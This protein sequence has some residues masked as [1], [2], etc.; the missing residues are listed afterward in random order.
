MGFSIAQDTNRPTRYK[1]R[2]AKSPCKC[3][4]CTVP[5]RENYEGKTWLICGD[6]ACDMKCDC[7]TDRPVWKCSFIE[8]KEEVLA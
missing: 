2:K 8:I 3:L 1:K 7:C 5:R 6:E 4:R